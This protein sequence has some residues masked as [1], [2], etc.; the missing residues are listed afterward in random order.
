MTRYFD[1]SALVKRYVR[2]AGSTSVRRLLASGTAATSDLPALAIVELIP[3]VTAGARALLLRHPLRAG[4]AVQLAS[5][6]YLQRQLA[7][8]VTFVAF[9]G[10]LVTAARA[11]GLPVAGTGRATPGGTLRKASRILKRPGVGKP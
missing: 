10:R 6:L 5:C 8:P 9:D 2:E 4:D 1:A 3:E 7:R 11:E